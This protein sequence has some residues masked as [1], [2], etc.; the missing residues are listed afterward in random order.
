MRSALAVEVEAAVGLVCRLG[1]SSL[2]LAEEEEVRRGKG[3]GR[4]ERRGAQGSRLRGG[5]GAGRSES[6]V[7]SW[8]VDLT[9]THIIGIAAEGYASLLAS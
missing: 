7:R 6:G 1:S 9:H 4:G 3:V 8:L 5:W 2:L